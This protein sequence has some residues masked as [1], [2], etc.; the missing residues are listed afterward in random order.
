MRKNTPGTDVGSDVDPQRLAGEEAELGLPAGAIPAALG[1]ASLVGAGGLLNAR[2]LAGAAAAPNAAAMRGNAREY[3][4]VLP[5]AL[6]AATGGITALG[7]RPLA[8]VA[9]G[10]MLYPAARAKKKHLQAAA[11][12]DA[13]QDAF[14]DAARAGVKGPQLARLEE[15]ARTAA[16]QSSDAFANSLRWGERVARPEDLVR[17]VR[18]VGIGTALLGT[19][20]AG[21]GIY[22]AFSAPK[23]APSV[24]KQAGARAALAQYGVKAASLGP[25]PTNSHGA[26]LGGAW[27]T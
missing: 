12:L 9:E 16:R 27:A 11:A 7:A 22:D 23:V 10:L 17:G 1:S 2:L 18:N 24:E 21:K 20:L 26:G 14:D 13:H 5:G 19:A 15:A 3:D 8:R 25:S 4:L 6:F